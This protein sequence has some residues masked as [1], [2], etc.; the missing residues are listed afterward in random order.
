MSNGAFLAAFGLLV[1]LSGCAA[2]GGQDPLLLLMRVPLAKWLQIRALTT[3]GL[4]LLLGGVAL[5]AG[6]L[7]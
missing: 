6:G 7:P 2:S 5:L 1:F 4:L 3:G